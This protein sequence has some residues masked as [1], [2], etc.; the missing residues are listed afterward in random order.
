[1]LVAEQDAVLVAEQDA[2]LI[3]EPVVEQDAVLIAEQDAA[4]V[5]EPAVEQDAAAVAA[6]IGV[7][8]VEQDAALVAEPAVELDAAAAAP[9]AVDVGPCVEAVV[10]Q[11]QLVV[12]RQRRSSN[13][14]HTI[15]PTSIILCT[16]QRI[17]ENQVTRSILLM[18]MM[19]LVL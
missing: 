9:V 11:R 17:Q 4:L 16:S 1:V 10:H 14:E 18:V 15:Q 13:S 6:L 8:A 3:A 7:T 12:S 19:L 2:V 5:A